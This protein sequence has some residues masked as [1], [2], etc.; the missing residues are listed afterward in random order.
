MFETKK[1]DSDGLGPI[2]GL[3]LP[4]TCNH[5]GTD[6]MSWWLG[7]TFMITMGCQMEL[8]WCCQSLS[9]RATYLIMG[10]DEMLS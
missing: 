8:E 3:S 4:V 5:S 1:A 2:L 9:H 7:T 6:I 10:E